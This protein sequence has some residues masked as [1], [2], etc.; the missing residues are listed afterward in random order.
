MIIKLHRSGRSFKGAMRYL[1]HDAGKADTSERVAW[2]AT[3]NLANDHIPS[4]VDEMIWTAR[5]AD[6]IKRAAGISTGGSKIEYPAEHFS[7]SWHTS[8]APTREEMIEATKC[9][10]KHMGMETRQAVI[11]AHSDTLHPHVHVLV[12]VISPEDGRALK[13]SYEYRRTQAFALAYEKERG[14]IFCEERTKP[15]KDREPSMTRPAHEAFK[16]SG[17]AFERE[18]L[19]RVTKMPGYFD[20][21]DAKTMNSKEWDALKAHQK[22][23]REQFFAEGKAA[24]R[25]AS[26]S[27]YREVR[28]E[29]RN[30][31]SAVYAAGRSGSDP[32]VV[33]ASKAALVEAQKKAIDERREIM[34]GELRKRRDAEYA[35]ILKQQQVD[36]GE[37][38]KQQ[39]L[40]ERTYRLFD[41][42]YPGAEPSK[43]VVEKPRLE[44]RWTA[45]DQIAN[46]AATQESFNRS[47]RTADPSFEEPRRN[48]ATVTRGTVR[49]GDAVEMTDKRVEANRSDSA[50]E[51]TDKAREREIKETEA[52]I[53]AS[54]NRH[55]RGR[56]ER[57]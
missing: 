21:H 42:I 30:K 12:N 41:V 3:V 26:K 52:I 1:I 48:P 20:R 4:A 13:T 16:Q 10:M 47:R 54:W 9:Y 25:N 39:Q 15:A 18:E 2:T 7:L 19:E 38:A 40:G 27:V 51:M 49:E 11:V 22:T 31:W 5:A 32:A 8:E 55:R 45:G 50:R 53:R 23:Q 44:Q 57:D 33:A 24:F 17:Q 56:S 35:S 36:R 28:Q 43:P 6:Q 37:L 34:N 46:P 14:N 29:Y